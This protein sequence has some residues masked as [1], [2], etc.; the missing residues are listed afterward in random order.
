[1]TGES[2]RTWKEADAAASSQRGQIDD[3]L[4]VGLFVLVLIGGA[5][6]GAASDL[7]AGL[8]ESSAFSWFEATVVAGLFLV[9]L[10]AMVLG[11][12]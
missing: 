6:V 2:L 1:M 4:I 9:A 5:L 7:Q 11:I 8:A 3:R 10:V 12:E